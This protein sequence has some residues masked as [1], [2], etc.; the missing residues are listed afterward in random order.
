MIAGITG[1]SWKM[2]GKWRMENLLCNLTWKR[3]YLYV[4]NQLCFRYNLGHVV[5]IYFHYY[6]NLSIIVYIVWHFQNKS[7]STQQCLYLVCDAVTWF[8][9]LLQVRAGSRLG[10]AGQG[11][12]MMSSASP[13]QPPAS[14]SQ[15]S[16]VVRPQRGRHHHSVSTHHVIWSIISWYR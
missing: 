1:S 5:D 14:P 11:W 3:A 7:T 4:H 13:S 6:Y 10:R 15:L 9:W 16:S 12:A 8:W 2:G